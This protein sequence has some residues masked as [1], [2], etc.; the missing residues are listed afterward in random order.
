VLRFRSRRFKDLE[1]VVLR[2]EVAILRRQVAHPEL[3]PADRVTEGDAYSFASLRGGVARAAGANRCVP[4]RVLA[5]RSD[6]QK[7][8]R[9]EED[10]RGRV[11]GGRACG[12]QKL[13]A[14]CGELVF[15]DEAPD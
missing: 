7:E 15:V 6:Q 11:S 1:I 12:V 9:H 2:H 8:A 4:W 14:S 13:R 5:L 3:R 10:H